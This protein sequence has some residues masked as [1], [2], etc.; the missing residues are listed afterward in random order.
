MKI[1]DN[2]A[3]SK[4]MMANYNVGSRWFSAMNRWVKLR[5]RRSDRRM[6]RNIIEEALR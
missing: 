3:Q 4:R 2:S 6:K 1:H 5:A